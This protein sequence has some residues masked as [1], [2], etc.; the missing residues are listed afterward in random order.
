MVSDTGLV[1]RSS[2]R[3][4]KYYNPHTTDYRN[5]TT[6]HHIRITVAGVRLPYN[7]I[8]ILVAVDS[9]AEINHNLVHA[10]YAVIVGVSG[11][12]ECTL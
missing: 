1:A 9:V 5:I 3:Y 8:R 4:R 7:A 11:G 12:V 2:S 6:I 10:A